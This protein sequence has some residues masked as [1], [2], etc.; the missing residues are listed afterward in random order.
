[1]SIQ[2][3]FYNLSNDERTTVLAELL[4]TYINGADS[5]NI[6]ELATAMAHD[7]RTLIQKKFGLF[8]Q[9]TK[10][11]SNFHMEGHFDA[12]NEYSCQTAAKIMTLTE[13]N[14]HVPFI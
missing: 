8:L 14:T 7:H 10:V 11:L 3:D 6:K 12:R 4:S 13:N 5:N 9:F 2:G 1:M